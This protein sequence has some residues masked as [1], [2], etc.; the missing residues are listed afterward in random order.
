MHLSSDNIIKVLKDHRQEMEHRFSL[1]RI[2]LFG[3]YL[4]GN[5]DTTSDIDLLVELANPSFDA[6]MDL[7]FYLEAL[8]DKRVDLVLADSLKPRIR[9]LILKEALNA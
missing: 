6:Y 5:P 8:F 7:K 9:P 3:S 2:A 4:H 1:Q